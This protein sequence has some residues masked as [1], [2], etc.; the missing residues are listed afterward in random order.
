MAT[1]LMAEQDHPLSPSLHFEDDA[2]CTTDGWFDATRDSVLAEVKQI[3]DVVDPLWR[4]IGLGGCP[5]A[6]SL[7]TGTL[8][9][10]TRHILRAGFV[11]TKPTLPQKARARVPS[12][13]ER[14]G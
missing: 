10:G 7:G 3:M 5:L 12:S 2:V 13:K 8:P 9:G 6:Y 1:L 4:I 14:Y 11:E